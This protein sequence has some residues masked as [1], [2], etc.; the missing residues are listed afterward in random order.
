MKRDS[1][2]LSGFFGFSYKVAFLFGFL[3]SLFIDSVIF[4]V[5]SVQIPED[6]T[7]EIRSCVFL[8]FK[9]AWVDIPFYGL[10]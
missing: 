3:F 1:K 4:L 7:L 9:I 5:G 6:W 10:L 2:K 8:G